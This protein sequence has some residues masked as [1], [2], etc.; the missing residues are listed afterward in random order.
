MF[1]AEETVKV[2]LKHIMGKL[3]PTDRT[4]SVTIATRADSSTYTANTPQSF[5]RVLQGNRRL[6]RPHPALKGRYAKLSS[7]SRVDRDSTGMGWDAQHSVVLGEYERGYHIIAGFS[8]T[9]RPSGGPGFL[10][11]NSHHPFTKNIACSQ[12]KPL[13]LRTKQWIQKSS[14]AKYQCEGEILDIFT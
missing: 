1:I 13:T 12:Y 3:G 6:L 10:P 8:A 7:Q 14:V 9:G 2:H 5:C 11:T 4:H